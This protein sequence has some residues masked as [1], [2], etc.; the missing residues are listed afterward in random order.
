LILAKQFATA[1]LAV[2]IFML[3]SVNFVSLSR[4]GAVNHF[5]TRS[6]SLA[7]NLSANVG[8]INL[9]PRL[10]GLSGALLQ[11]GAGVLVGQISTQLGNAFTAWLADMADAVTQYT[12]DLYH[13]FINAWSKFLGFNKTADTSNLSGKPTDMVALKAQIKQE[14]YDQLKQELLNRPGF[15]GL[16]AFPSTGSTSTD[17]TRTENIKQMFS[18]K[19]NVQVSPDGKS[20]TVKPIFR[21]RLGGNYLF[22]LSPDNK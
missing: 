20:G 18:D 12:I 10:D 2:V 9:A 11:G 17:L 22:L 13:S 1:L 8:A 14:V 3:L 6:I 19:V 5:A 4:L 7:D 16:S 15:V 21:D